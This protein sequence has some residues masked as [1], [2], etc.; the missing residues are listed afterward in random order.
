MKRVSIPI[1]L[2][3]PALKTAVAQIMQSPSV[4]GIE[5]NSILF[6][7]LKEDENSI[8]DIIEGAKFS[9]TLG[10]SICVLR[11]S[12]R[13]FGYKKHIH[14]WLTPGDF[15]NANLMILLAY[16]LLGHPEWR[17]G[18]IEIFAAFNKADMSKEMSRPE[19]AYR[20]RTYT[21]FP[22]TCQTGTL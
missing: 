5:N 19:Q 7:F 22:K 4:F 17:G 13:H 11:S 10:F 6:E 20:K 16:I 9:S 15:A 8:S 1:R 3:H 12:S 18:Q 21:C 14:I 2:S